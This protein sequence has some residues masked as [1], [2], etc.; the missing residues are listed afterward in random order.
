MPITEFRWEHNQGFDLHVLRNSLTSLPLDQ[1][2]IVVHQTAAGTEA[3][4]VSAINGGT[5]TRPSD[6]NRVRFVPRF[7]NTINAAGNPEANGI[8]VDINTGAITART[9]AAPKI[10]NFILEAILSRTGTPTPPDLKISIRVNVHDDIV[11]AWLTP[12]QLTIRP[13]ATK[14][15]SEIVFKYVGTNP[16]PNIEIFSDP[17]FTKRLGT[18]NGPFATGNNI[19]LRTPS[20]F[21]PLFLFP[22][23]VFPFPLFLQIP[24][25]PVRNSSIPTRSGRLI[26]V[27]LKFGDFEIVSF[28]ERGQFKSSVYAE[29]DDGVVGD[30][31]QHHGITWFNNAPAAADGV[32]VEADGA[33]RAA[34]SAVGKSPNIEATLPARISKTGVTTATGK[35]RVEPSW[36]GATV[37]ATLLAGG[38][39]LTRTADVPNVI[40]LSDGFTSQASFE[41]VV[42]AIHT[43]LRTS[44]KTSPW[45]HLFTNSMNAWWAFINSQEAAA[46]ILC[47]NAFV[48]IPSKPSVAAP[49]DQVVAAAGKLRLT[50]GE[51]SLEQLIE[52]VGL[53]VTA[54]IGKTLTTKLGEWKTFFD[55]A[56]EPSTGSGTKKVNS[57]VF[58][59]WQRLAERRLL[60][61]RDTVL[62]ISIGEKPRHQNLLNSNQLTYNTLARINRRNLDQFLNSLV[63]STGNPIGNNW[64]QDALNK[65]GKDYSLVIILSAGTLLVG[66]RNESKEGAELFGS[67]I[68]TALVDNRLSMATIAASASGLTVPVS[69][70]IAISD[71]ISPR[72]LRIDPF[73]IPTVIPAETNALVAHE[74]C[75]EFRLGDEYARLENAGRN[76]PA[77]VVTQRLPRHNLQ[78]ETTL[79]TGGQIDT[80]KILWRWPRIRK[81]GVLVKQ[82]SP[83][84]VSAG[85][86]TI[87]LRTGHGSLFGVTE[88]VHLR[89][90]DLLTAASRQLS[91]KLKITG[92]SGDVL[93]LAP[94]PSATIDLSSFGPESLLVQ[95]VPASSNSANNPT[96]D[97]FAE[98]L[99]PLMRAQ[100]Q[101]STPPKPQTVRPCAQ[102]IRDTQAP[103]NFPT[104]LIRPTSSTLPRIVG[105]F[106]GGLEFSCGIYHPSGE[107]IMRSNIKVVGGTRTVTQFCPVCKYALVDRIDPTQH[108][109]IDPEYDAEYP[110][111][112]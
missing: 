111:K 6:Y 66:T 38:P 110:R 65:R 72:A 28:V 85:P 92:I 46:T 44:P 18:L 9:Q 79:L 95:P 88:E 5:A 105:L 48:T 34:A 15:I 84:G 27:G 26:K 93:T 30:V 90:R 13:D 52:I 1:I 22:E 62:G 61:E 25:T 10:S 4:S 74:M 47:E 103:I 78:E 99:S 36:V 51:L 14:G 35:V 8:E 73:P 23:A 82:P 106:A 11:K 77:S 58:T 21:F 94:V 32:T 39:G 81:A 60:N 37:T 98:L 107:C 20:P 87:E 101:G 96:A 7:I 45:N 86:F 43:E 104:G 91:H 56:L 29:F 57:Q 80:N 67:G 49:M 112:V 97:V 3:P 54:D 55:S 76:V 12:S 24:G 83:A 102:D 40:F 31:T 71:P 42:R 59:L 17:G 69:H 89:V 64:S 109:K 70:A 2:A 100:I 16:A 53:A 68:M 63:D 75:H 33:M 50:A 19:I 41:R 108:A